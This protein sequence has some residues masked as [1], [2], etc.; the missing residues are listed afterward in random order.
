MASLK[1]TLI[2]KP[3]KDGLF[4]ATIQINHDY[5]TRRITL[6]PIDPKYFIDG[7]VSKRHKQYVR[8]N[9]IIN[10]EKHKYQERIDRLDASGIPYHI[11]DI[12]DEKPLAAVLLIDLIRSYAER[13]RDINRHPMARQMDNLADMVE[14][15]DPRIRVKDV[16]PPWINRLVDHLRSQSTI[17]SDNTVGKYIKNLRTALRSDLTDFNDKSVFTYRIPKSDVEIEALTTEEM[18]VWQSGTIPA[19]LEMYR[20][21]FTFMVHCHGLRVSDA[22]TVR[23]IDIKNGY[24][25]IRELKTGSRKGLGKMKKVLV[26]N[27]LQ[28]IIDKYAGHSKYYIFPMLTKEPDDPKTNRDYR[29][30]LDVKISVANRNLKLIAAHLGIDKNITN[31]VARHT[32]A[33]LVDDQNVDIRDIQQMLNHS[34]LEQ[35]IKYIH[36]LRRSGHI[37]Q[38]AQKAL[39]GLE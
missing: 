1:L 31:H 30:H 3:N 34:K 32:F 4:P 35:T 12:M 8:L 24:I 16:K 13:Q 36:R 7:K 27:V 22:L 21:F 37:N 9:N 38:E 18:K 33:S 25:Q 5:K 10:R 29:K 20:D 14:A 19:N 26:N 23:T 15:F 39:R 17:N 6:F 28:T 11:D 2:K